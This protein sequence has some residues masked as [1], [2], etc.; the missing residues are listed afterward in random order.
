MP[1]PSN[2][3]DYNKTPKSLGRASRAGVLWTTARS[4]IVEIVTFPSTVALAQLLSPF[5]F[6]VAALAIFFGRL[7]ARVANAGMGSALVRTKELRN[8]HISSIFVANLALTLIADLALLVLAKPLATFY[9]APAIAGLM[10]V[11]ALDILFSALS[12]VSQALLARGMRYKEMA[13]LATA[14][15]LANAASS[16]VFAWLGFGYWSLVLGGACGSGLKWLWGVKL[17]GW[18]MSFRFVPSAARE[19]MSFAF[20]TYARGLL[21]YAS[22]TID[23]LVVG[24]VLGVTML[25]YYDKAFSTT[26]RAYNK[27]TV[28][29]PTVSF[30]TLAILQDDLVRFHRALEKILVSTTL[31]T[32]SG[33]AVLGAMGPHLI[34]FVFGEKWQPC[35]IPF[36]LLCASAALRTTNAFAGAAANARGWIWS[37]VWRQ[38]VYAGLIA[39]GVY[40]AGPWGING[41]SVAVLVATTVMTFLT[42]EMAK[43]ATETTWR[44][45]LTPQIPGSVLAV[46]LGG[47]VWLVDR[48][49]LR[50]GVSAH[51]PVLVAQT[52]VAGVVGIAAIRWT[53]F[54]IVAS[55]IHEIV[56]DV[57]PKLA[58]VLITREHAERASQVRPHARSPRSSS[59][60]DQG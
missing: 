37:N 29:G 26:Q 47:L 16:V 38:G 3:V 40:L 14:D 31:L 44:T 43:V 4:Y 46:L 35:V 57:S 52:V 9:K 25:G 58:S 49:F 15:A 28:G 30:R 5:D 60:A 32:Y 56:S 6:G 51:L 55:V 53:P 39:V 1:Q 33:F 2:I 23:N 19:L 48:L 7:A 36:Q 11:V 59:L 20:G 10:P 22:L 8:E 17:V 54:P 12:M 42:L 24:K 13:T 34:V 27:L 50:W 41:A 45:L 18:Q 21:E